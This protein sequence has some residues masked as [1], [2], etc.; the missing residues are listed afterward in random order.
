MATIEQLVGFAAQYNKIVER[1]HSGALDGAAVRRAL[2]DIIEGKS[3]TLAHNPPPWWRKPEQQLARARE[4]WPG[5]ELPEPPARFAPL[6]KTEVLL[7][8]VPASFEVLW[9]FVAA[10]DGYEKFRDRGLWSNSAHL[11]LTPNALKHDEPV[12]VAFDPEYGVDRPPYYVWDDMRHHVASSEVL[13]ALIQFPDWP[14]AWLH[15]AAAPHI[16][17]YRYAGLN[18]TWSRCLYLRCHVVPVNRLG[19][20]QDSASLHSKNWASPSVRVL[21]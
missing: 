17:G 8:H 5:T 6:T 2:Q 21:S 4:L 1:V 7:L 13:S 3:G 16:A 18:A 10:P 12:W 15:G 19:L 14:L 9:R 20:Y 11:R